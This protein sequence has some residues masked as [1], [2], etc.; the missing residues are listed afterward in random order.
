MQNEKKLHIQTPTLSPQD[1]ASNQEV[2]WCPGCGD[3]AILKAVQRV[4]SQLETPK[5]NFVFVSG[6]GCASR[7]PYY[8]STYGF[9]TIHGRAPCIATGIKLAKPELQVW[10]VTGDGDGLSIGANHLIHL[11]R[12]NVNVKVLLFN[13][14]IYG[15]TKGQYSPT[16][17]AGLKTKSSPFG[18]IESPLNPILVALAA[19]CSFVARG[20]D[21]D[22]VG[23][24]DIM[25]KAAKH[26][27]TSFIEIYQNCHVFNDGAFD[28]IRD[29]GARDANTI[30]LIPG[31]PLLFGKDNKR[32]LIVHSYG[33]EVKE[34]E[35]QQDLESITV[36]ESNLA[37][38][39][40]LA[41]MKN[42]NMP[43]PIGIFY[44]EERATFD[45]QIQNHI[46]KAKQ[47]KKASLEEV[48]HHGHT[49]EI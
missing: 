12:R 49:W 21:I 1:F 39:V 48:L 36:Y 29:K 4:L 20:I 28:T 24:P 43:V 5:E 35:T 26:Q 25:I 30:T 3:Y 19:Q 7:F 14:Q 40:Q 27:G 17:E 42:P 33:I 31:Q 44:Q 6:I 2:R 9:H 16:S 10:L 23:L 41:S 34:I 11:M 13:N 22:A 45:G 32:G 8:L 47:D 18:A 15:L 37:M 38:A 46:D